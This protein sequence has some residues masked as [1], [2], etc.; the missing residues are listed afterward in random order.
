MLELFLFLSSKEKE[1]LDLVI[2]AGYRVE[3]NTPLCLLGKRY[4]G[5]VKKPQKTV[6]ICTKNAKFMGNS[7]M[8]RISSYDEN[9]RTKLIIRRAVRHEAVHVAQACN[10]SRLLN[11]IKNTK[12]IHSW[13]KRD[14]LKGSMAITNIDEG[15][16]Y[17]AYLME[18]R[19]NLVVYALK[20]YC[21]KKT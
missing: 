5:F 2:K 21:I 1:I 11:L 3:E 20:K 6:V 10:G 18:D 15:R 9:S 14:A 16:E 17:E 19:P 7:S 12:H 4:F 13:Y 8:P